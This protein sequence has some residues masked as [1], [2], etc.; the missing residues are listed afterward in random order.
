MLV[1]IWLSN[2]PF[3]FI[4]GAAIHRTGK[5]FGVLFQKQ[6]PIHQFQWSD[7]KYKNSTENFFPYVSKIDNAT[8]ALGPKPD[9]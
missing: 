2:S 6:S 9:I 5:S 8:D 1:F 3:R 7:L 4:D